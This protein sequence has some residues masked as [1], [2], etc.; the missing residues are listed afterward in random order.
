M[1]LSFRVISV[2]VSGLRDFVV[3][4]SRNHVGEGNSFNNIVTSTSTTLLP[5][6]QAILSYTLGKS[7]SNAGL[8]GGEGEECCKW[9]G[10]NSKKSCDDLRVFSLTSPLGS[11]GQN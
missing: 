3:G 10:V 5:L 8:R 2:G 6:L 7:T 9:R 11:L 4:F 1:T